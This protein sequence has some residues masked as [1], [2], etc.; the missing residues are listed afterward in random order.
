MDSSL[1][2]AI[3]LC[4][5]RPVAVAIG[6]HWA[7]VAP[8]RVD[9]ARRLGGLDPAGRWTPLK[10]EEALPISSGWGELVLSRSVRIESRKEVRGR[11][12]TG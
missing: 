11:V 9:Q 8:R 1:Q 7:L 5:H 4:G 10:I 2:V 6:I 12:G 3:H